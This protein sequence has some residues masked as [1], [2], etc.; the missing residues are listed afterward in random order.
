VSGL[1]AYF[2]PRAGLSGPWRMDWL[3]SHV[4]VYAT[5]NLVAAVFWWLPYELAQWFEAPLWAGL[6]LILMAGHAV[7]FGVML[8]VLSSRA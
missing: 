8:G 3:L 7:V 2:L 1:L 5:R 6:C 4:R